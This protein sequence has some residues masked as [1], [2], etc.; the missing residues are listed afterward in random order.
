MTKLFAQRDFIEYAENEAGTSGTY[1]RTKQPTKAPS[2]EY[3]NYSDMPPIGDAT[4]EAATA[5]LRK[6]H[7]EYLATTDSAKLAGLRKRYFEVSRKLTSDTAT[8][9]GSLSDVDE[10]AFNTVGQTVTD[11]LSASIRVVTK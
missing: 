1:D 9:T 5:D 2:V 7:R 3:L 4:V 8:L 6:L 10:Q 11:L